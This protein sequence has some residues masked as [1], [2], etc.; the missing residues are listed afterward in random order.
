MSVSHRWNP[1]IVVLYKFFPS[2]LPPR[3][4]QSLAN[5]PASN[6]FII[7]SAWSMS[8]R[9]ESARPDFINSR[10]TET[11]FFTAFCISLFRTAASLGWYF[12]LN[13]HYVQEN[14][15]NTVATRNQYLL[16]IMNCIYTKVTWLGATPGHD[17]CDS[18][19]ECPYALVML[20]NNTTITIELLEHTFLK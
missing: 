20:L 16:C 17:L 11:L 6:N 4:I 2:L 19:W 18:D 3:W 14:I 1:N 13:L 5:T 7:S 10:K 9:R 8:R 12:P 15:F